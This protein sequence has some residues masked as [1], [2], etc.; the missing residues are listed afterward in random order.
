MAR[1]VVENRDSAFK[2]ALDVSKL[3]TVAV[4]E[5]THGWVRSRRAQ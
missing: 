4:S 1:S 5:P 3:H 2:A